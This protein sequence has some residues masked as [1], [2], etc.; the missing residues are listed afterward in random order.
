MMVK[1]TVCPTCDSKEIKKV[2][3]NWTG[4]TRGQTYTVPALAFY[5]CP[6][7]GEKIYDRQ[8]MQQIADHSPAYARRHSEKKSA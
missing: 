3:R 5:E 2:Q 1:I 8:A 4:K 7:C 6:A